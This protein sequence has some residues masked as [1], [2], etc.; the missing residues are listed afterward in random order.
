VEAGKRLEGGEVKPE[1]INRAIAEHC[2]WQFLPERDTRLGPQPELWEGP[3]G[4][5]FFESPFKDWP[6][7][8]NY[9]GDL[10]AMRKAENTLTDE[11][12][13]RY[14]FSL[15]HLYLE[16]SQYR[17]ALGAI[18]ATADQR[19]EAFLRTIGKWKESEANP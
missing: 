7:Y 12:F 19:A 16:L 17:S 6:P 15:Q 2:G 11:Q 9:H 5:R 18:S 3:D 4:D 8:P 14:C 13:G 10:N 1:D